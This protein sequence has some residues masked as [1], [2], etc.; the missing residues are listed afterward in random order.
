MMTPTKEQF[1]FGAAL[2]LSGFFAL[3]V[4]GGEGGSRV[5]AP[6]VPAI[7]EPVRLADHEVP[8]RWPAVV[9]EQPVLLGRNPFAAASVW[10][11][12]VPAPLG[13]PP[14]RAR[15]QLLPIL[16]IGGGRA[17]APEAPVLHLKERP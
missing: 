17:W 13:L 9:R 6:D 10:E 7:E 8:V 2:V 14:E 3:S 1:A 4:L 5:E 11:D 16:S 12:P 15:G